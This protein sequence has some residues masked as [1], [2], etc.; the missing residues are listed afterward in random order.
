[1]S[2]SQT[3][4][5][6]PE[7]QDALQASAE[8]NLNRLFAVE[9]E[10]PWYKSFIQNIREAFN[11]PKLPPLEVTSKPVPVKSIWGLYAPDRKNWG[12][13]AAILTVV[14]VLL[15]TVFSRQI[16]DA[17][18]KQ[19]L[20][21]VDPN[22]KPYV[23]DLKPAKQQAAGG[24]GGGDRSPTPASKGKLPK[25]ALKQFVPPVAVVRNLQP[26]LV[27]TPTIV[28]DMPLPN[29]N[30]PNI[31]DPLSRIAEASNGIGAGGG[32]G[33]GNRGGIGSGTGAGLG[34]G[35]GGGF[36]GGAF[37]AGGGVSS[38]ELLQKVEPEYSEE[39]RKAKQQGTVVLKVIV[40][41]DGRVREVQVIRPLGLGLDEK[42][43]EAVKKWSFKPGQKD[44]KAVAVIANI[45]VNFHL[46]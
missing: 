21:L 18:K 31:G 45:E 2:N 19:Q 46:L 36:G 39:A 10:E 41:V 20:S 29:L 6:P 12:Y 38:P 27:M 22:L 26:K 8:E 9:V 44:G 15:G 34:P 43:I 33:S 11:P 1:M 4:I 3:T 23:P 40:G 42:A 28:A 25:I 14:V 5:D 17:V 13:S 37:R 32:I 35:S 7:I 30:S 16:M 24:G